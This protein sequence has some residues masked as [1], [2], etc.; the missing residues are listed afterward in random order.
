MKETIFIKLYNVLITIF[1][2][3]I[4][5]AIALK[6]FKHKKHIL[7]HFGKDIE[8][9]KKQ[10]IWIHAVSVG[11][12]HLLK[13]LINQLSTNH[14]IIVSTVT[15]TGNSA[16]K[17]IFDNK[18]KVVYFPI[19][20]KPVIDK[21][22]KLI[23]PKLIILVETEIWPN[24]LYETAKKKI[25]VVL[26]NGRISERSSKWYRRLRFFFKPLIGKIAMICVQNED[27]KKHF[28]EYQREDRIAVTGNLKYANIDKF[29]SKLKKPNDKIVIVAGSTHDGEEKMI[30]NIFNRLK[31]H[32]QLFLIIAPR[33]LNRL[34]SVEDI[35]RKY[36]LHPVRL[37]KFD[38]Y[39]SI[40]TII[41]DTVGDLSSLYEIA[42]IA[43]IGGSMTKVG[44]H[45]PIEACLYSVP[46]IMGKYYFN[47]DQIIS[48]LVEHKGIMIAANIDDFQE[49]LEELLQSRGKRMIIGNAGYKVVNSHVDDLKKTVNIL[50]KFL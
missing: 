23:N 5:S 48:E 8:Q 33:H 19:D 22:I 47:F 6:S 1:F 2:P 34:N 20:Y 35:A 21:Y 9:S 44:G 32:R 13:K 41:V 3:I 12:V 17:L 30:F 40:D 16:A 50:Q 24:F 45:N 46:V 11:E 4:F 31:K 49:K 37:T 25:P 10:T 36:K 26:I 15:E 7:S 14:L 18:A 39:N 28:L 42:D 27:E 29:E 38:G 43:F